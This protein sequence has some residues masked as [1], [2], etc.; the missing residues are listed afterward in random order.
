[1]AA[2]A[3]AGTQMNM[4][5]RDERTDVYMA[6]AAAAAAGPWTTDAPVVLL[7]RLPGQGE[8][9]V[10]HRQLEGVGELEAPERDPAVSVSGC[11]RGRVCVGVWAWVWGCV[12]MCVWGGGV[13]CVGWVTG[14]VDS[15]RGQH[16]FVVSCGVV[17]GP[18][19]GCISNKKGKVRPLTLVHPSPHP[20]I[21]PPATHFLA[22]TGPPSRP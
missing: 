1:M 10:V 18:I 19:H 20:S 22:A 3:A 11:V 14:Y 15:V 4:H 7:P 21:H 16:G 5:V 13:V 12:G 2:A 8:E 6:A 9:E 17:E